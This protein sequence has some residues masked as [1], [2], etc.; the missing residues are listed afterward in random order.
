MKPLTE[1][2]LR[3]FIT[4]VPRAAPLFPEYWYLAD[5]YKWLGGEP[6]IPSYYKMK[7]LPINARDKLANYIYQRPYGRYRQEYIRWA[8]EIFSPFFNSL[9]REKV[10]AITGRQRE[11]FLFS[12]ET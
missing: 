11:I 9:P 5:F 10:R 7:S 4:E 12:Y 6:Y 2:N 3:Q 1:E 8:K